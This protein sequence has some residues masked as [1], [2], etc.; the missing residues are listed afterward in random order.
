[1]QTPV[2]AVDVGYGN[3]KWAHR[4]DAGIVTGMFPSLAPLAATGNL[5]SYGSDVLMSR[6][7]TKVQVEGAHYEVGPDVV[8]TSAYGDT[9]RTLSEDFSVSAS[10]MALLGGAFFFT[11]VTHM[12]RLALGLPVHNMRKYADELKQRYAGTH[13]FGHGPVVVEKVQ[14]MPQPL[15]SLVFA[16]GRRRDEFTRD[17]AHLII[18][19][20]YFTTDWVYANGFTMDEKRSGGIPGG[21][22]HI[23]ECIAEAISA[24]FGEV[25]TDYDRID[26]ALR[27]KKRF[28][29]YGEHIDLAPY[30]E[31]AV[32]LINATIKSIAK[33][34]G[35]L[36]DVRSIILSGGGAALYA[37]ALQA[38]FPRVRVEVLDAP[39]MTNAKGFLAIGEMGIARER[40]LAQQSA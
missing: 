2:F 36:S 38:A 26:K 39:C 10:Y 21:A 3:T 29:F 14:V 11:G 4:G 25:V 33:M 40:T 7:V 9:G 18:D 31:K 37:A 22:S 27:E 17:S 35:R 15:G 19:V 6:R 13:D 23:Y 28:F 5:A 24:D 16:S 30:L 8:I 12:Q 1:M 32:P 20:G 34:V